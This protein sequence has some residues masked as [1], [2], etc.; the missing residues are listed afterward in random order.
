MSVEQIAVVGVVC[1]LL[2]AYV[3]SFFRRKPPEPSFFCQKCKG[4]FP[5]NSR[6]IE[7]WRNKKTE[8]YC[9][10]CHANWLRHNPHANEYGKRTKGSGCL[11][12]LVLGVVAPP[13]AVAISTI[14][15][16]VGA[17]V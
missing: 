10:T 11:G 3:S 17:V 2:L 4:T 16:W 9:Q 13:L 1:V 15:F 5:H 8:F 12:I 14:T 7:A 6:T